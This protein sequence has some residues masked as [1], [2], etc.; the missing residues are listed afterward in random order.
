MTLKGESPQFLGS[1]TSEQRDDD[2]GVKRPAL[3]GS[4]ERIGLIVGQRF[5]RTALLSLRHVAKEHDVA[6]YLVPSLSP[7]DGPPES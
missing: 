2:V 5:R 4:Q 7:S 3:G 6:L 1:G